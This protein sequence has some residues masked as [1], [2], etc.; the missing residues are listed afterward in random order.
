MKARALALA[1]AL[2]AATTGVGLG[3]PQLAGATTVNCPA[4]TP[5]P[6]TAVYGD[7]NVTGTCVVNNV[8]VTGSVTIQNGGGLELDSS[9]V[10]GNVT[11]NAGGELDSGA[12]LGVGSPNGKSST[13]KGRLVYAGGDMDFIGGGIQGSA[14]SLSVDGT[15]TGHFPKVCGAGI[16]HGV[17]VQNVPASKSFRLGDP[18]HDDGSV[19]AANG[20]R[21]NVLFQ[22]NAGALVMEGNGVVGNVSIVGS[23]VKFEDNGINGNLSCGTGGH[24]TSASGNTVSGPN[25]C[26][27]V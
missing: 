15:N 14:P 25:T 4:T 1:I 10:Q 27:A 3:I 19:C 24:V 13:V 2:T 12:T 6:G 21:G 9:V 22:S 17:T 20:I 23:T 16:S 8:T 26:G 11:V 7:L 5:A 18:D